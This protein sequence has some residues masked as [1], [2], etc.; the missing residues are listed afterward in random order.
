MRDEPLPTTIEVTQGDTPA[1]LTVPDVYPKT[2]IDTAI[3]VNVRQ[4]DSATLSFVTLERLQ[5]ETL[6]TISPG[7]DIADG[8]YDLILES[9]DQLSN[10]TILQVDTITITLKANKGFSTKMLTAGVP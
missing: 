7:Y 5:G 3:D 8:D 6:I 10:D 1:T 2:S 4:L 9:F